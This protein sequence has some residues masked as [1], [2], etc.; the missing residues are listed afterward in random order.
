MLFSHRKGLKF[1]RSVIQTDEMDSVL[2]NALWDIL[3]VTIWDEDSN[4][5]YYGNLSESTL[6]PLFRIYWHKYFN[7][8]IDRLPVKTQDA[9]ASVREYYFSC[10]WYEVYDFMEFTANHIKKN[11]IQEFTEFS[12]KVLERE[13]SGYRF[14]N[15]KIVQ[16][17]TKEEI[18]SI[19]TA[20]VNTSHLNGAN[21]HLRTSLDLLSD[22]KKPDYRN[23]IK[24]SISAVESLSQTITG[25][26][27][28]TLGNALKELEKRYAI[29]PALKAGLSSLY[30]YTSDSDG[31]RHAMLDE[32]HLSFT[33]AKFMLVACTAF[34]NYLTGKAA[35]SGASLD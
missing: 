29:H 4:S 8:P 21:A 10:E 23:S 30:G 7:K 1:V 31:I 12:N 18:E 6:Q 9:V 14:V 28:A 27:K 13:L 35:E 33:D 34:I 2:R 26:P 22:R 11:E 5:S 16:I 25:D 20:L 15:N 17:S 32:S 24:E 19:E 3:Q